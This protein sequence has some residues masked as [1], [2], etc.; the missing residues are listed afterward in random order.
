MGETYKL[1]GIHIIK[2]D[3]RDLKP[4]MVLADNI[5]SLKSGAVLITK[6]TIL[7]KTAIA[8]II[9]QGIEE[10]FI[11]DKDDTKDISDI[12]TDTFVKN[13][14]ALS[15]K[16]E[17]IFRNIRFGKKIILTEVSEEVDNLIVD[18]IQND[19]ILGRIRQIEEKDDFLFNHSLNVFMLAT[20]MGKW[21]N[22]SEKKIKQLALAGL[23]HDI[24]KLK[25]PDNIVNKSSLLTEDEE[26][27]MKKHSIYSYNILSETI[28][29]SKNTLLG[30]LQHH[31]REDGSGYPQRL[32]ED[33]IHEYAKIIA[34]CDIYDTFTF[35]KRYKHRRSPFYAARILEQQSF[36]ILNAKVSRLFLDKISEFYVGCQVILSNEEIGKIIYVNPQNSTKPIVKVGE[37]YINFSESQDLSI[38]EIV[39]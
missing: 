2:I 29:I 15:G 16:V 4:G 35:D 30:V 33:K 17:N 25:I 37:K 22:Y 24:G 32:K 12:K 34:V 14:E 6:G 18:I 13:Y 3:T 20:M 19:N 5:G 38:V 31:E 23:F 8:S 36:G 28:G 10:V 9:S 27:T 39:K 1:G 21:L 11:Y 7:N 26:N